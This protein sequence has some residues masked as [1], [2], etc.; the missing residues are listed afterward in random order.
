MNAA[1]AAHARVDPAHSPPL[2]GFEGIS[3]YW[4]PH[5][6]TLAAK[7][8]PGEHYVTR[9]D[10]MITTG[11]GSC[12]SDCV[13]EPVARVGGV[14]PFLLR[15]CGAGGEACWGGGRHP[16]GRRC[17]PLATKRHGFSTSSV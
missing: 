4:D 1:G 9:R 13:R 12:V 5:L 2:P 17:L 11:L 14:S 6:C 3:R 16:V 7:L 8:L 15:E 10:E